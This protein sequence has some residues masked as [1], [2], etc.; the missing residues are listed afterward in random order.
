[1]KIFMKVRVKKETIFFFLISI[2]A[3]LIVGLRGN[4][5]DT[6]DYY[7]VFKNISTL[8][9]TDPIQFYAHTGM[10]IGFG[11]FAYIVHIFTSSSVI[12]FTLFS[13][14]NFY[15]IYKT[16]RLLGIHYFY[17]F[18]FYSTSAYFF[19]QQFM[20]MRQGLAVCI[21]IFTVVY[22]IKKGFKLWQLLLVLLSVAIHQTAA[23]LIAFCSIFYFLRNTFLFS[24]K[25]HKTT[26]WA[27]FLIFVVFFKFI[28]LNFLIN[29]SGRLNSYATSDTYNEAI[30]LFSLPNIRTF[31]ILM[32]LTYFSGKALNRN[33][34]FRLFLFLMF[35]ALAIRVGFSDFGIMSGRLSTAF[36]YVEIFA[37]PMLLIDRFKLR[38]RIVFIIIICI[39]QLIITLG[40]QAPYLF[41][42]YFEP[43][44]RY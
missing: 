36:S 25:Y 44:Y 34:H 5:N 11:W 27:L 24:D 10:E 4:T 33:I 6:Q 28:L 31:L 8:P 17:P 19:M 15:L 42:M 1:M 14:L 2:V 40:F 12:M 30:S 22:A 7:D 41:E 13:F 32:A 3:S 37:L 9:V 26:Y 39:A 21:V 43:L 23:F 35:T 20:Q 38:A 16:A 29:F 18:C